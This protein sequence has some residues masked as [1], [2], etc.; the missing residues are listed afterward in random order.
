MQYGWAQV[1]RQKG[2]YQ[3]D[4]ASDR[5]I[6]EASA[7]GLQPLLVLGQG[8]AFYD[9]GGMPLSDAAQAAFAQ[10]AAFLAVRYKGVVKQYEVWSEWNVGMGS[11][12]Q[13]NQGDA[14]AYAR[15]LAKVHAAIKAVD[16]TI[17]VLGGAIRTPDAGW[18]SGLFRAGGLASLD[19]LSV[20]PYAYPDGPERSMQYLQALAADALNSNGTLR[21][22]MRSSNTPLS[23]IETTD[24][25]CGK[26]ASGPISLNENPRASLR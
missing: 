10:Y 3:I 2:Q 4:P 24:A 15:L 16:P 9:R 8:N 19:G 22:S 5:V 21:R 18:S 13:V 11:V 6:R 20:H 23:R 12:P 25:H 17:V 1:E 7:Q 26:D 14:A